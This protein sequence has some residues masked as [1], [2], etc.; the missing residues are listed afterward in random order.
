MGRRPRSYA[1]RVAEAPRAAKRKREK[2]GGYKIINRQYEE[3]INS[4]S[5]DQQE[6]ARAF[7]EH[8]V[9]GKQISLTSA[10]QRTQRLLYQANAD[11]E[12]VD[13]FER[14]PGEKLESFI[15]TLPEAERERAR[16]QMLATYSAALERSTERNSINARKQRNFRARNIESVR[17]AELAKTRAR[18]AKQKEARQEVPFVAIDAEGINVES[19]FSVEADDPTLSL[20]LGLPEKQSADRRLIAQ[21]HR[22]FLWGASG[23]DG[24]AVWLGDGRKLPL[25][26]KNICAWL[27]SLSL[28]FP[29]AIFIMFAAGYD[30]TQ[31]FR[32][33]PYE[34]AWEI[35]NGLP[36][37]EQENSTGKM[38]N[39]RRWVL[40][41]QFGLR[42]YPG[43]YLEIATFRNRDKIKNAEGKFDIEAKIKIYDTFGFFQSS[44]LKA[45]TG[46]GGDFLQQ[47]EREIL[48]DGKS[49]RGA[50]VE[51]PFAEIQ[52]YTLVELRVLA[53]MITRLRSGLKELEL[54]LRDWHGA[55]CIAQAMMTK[56]RVV[57]YYPEFTENVNIDDFSSPLAWGLR[58]FFGGRIELMKQ[59]VYDAKFWNYDISSAYPH[60]QRQ[61]PNMKK[62]RWILHGSSHFNPTDLG[63]APISAF[64]RNLPNLQN[65]SLQLETMSLVSMV[66]LR[67]YFPACHRQ[68][69]K[70]GHEFLALADLPWFPLPIRADDGT[71]YFPRQGQGIY[72]VEEARAMLRWAQCIY[73]KAKDSELPL[74]DVMSAMEFVPVNNAKPFKDRI[75]RGFEER[76]IIIQNNEIEK[77]KRKSQ[78]EDGPEPYDVR[79][80]VL[81][82]GLNSIYGKTA[83]SKGM[84][85]V[86][87]SDGSMR[88]MPP[89]L[90]NTYYAAAI[91]AGA[92]AMLLDAASADVDAHSFRDRRYLFYSAAG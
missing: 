92:R 38:S 26:G 21:D 6:I 15:A 71:I 37:S 13:F 58:G 35:Q 39:R 43:K 47:A 54:T 72:M 60:V 20:D 59:G 89:R 40:W 9:D 33:M 17:V 74:I 22:T 86:R 50:F 34:K 1:Q 10:A 18:R 75:E 51:V 81:K 61:L 79:E 48:E 90:S 49:R 42:F 16:T 11:R 56:D 32:D 3:L 5:E 66:R 44:F 78:G 53:R 29:G 64:K 82:L 80:K 67:F 46:F 7:H 63:D 23:D 87:D 8:T 27:V 76:A 68:V 30:W 25:A 52:R 57:D 91:T 77:E 41:G 36:W 73:S 65:I 62:G 2:R 28:Q 19:P 83:Q 4:L 69:L 12:T 70:A 31:I 55:G 24:R 84:R 45:A 88:A 85:V 14:L